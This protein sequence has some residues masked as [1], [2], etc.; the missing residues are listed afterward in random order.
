[1]F[2]SVPHP[3]TVHLPLAIAVL[4]PLLLVA[5]HWS[6]VKGVFSE[7]MYLFAI[8][9]SLL[10]LIAIGIAYVSGLHDMATASGD[11]NLL[12]QHRSWGNLFAF[13]WLILFSLLAV[14]QF[15]YPRHL[16]SRSSW[17]LYALAGAQ[18]A[19]GI[20]LGHLGGLLAYG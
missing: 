15:K 4:L 5:C 9:L 13:C 7:K 20:W 17:L 1:M 16:T 2:L 8:G 6:V 19:A 14:L 3:A 18:L 10:Q 12:D 11:P